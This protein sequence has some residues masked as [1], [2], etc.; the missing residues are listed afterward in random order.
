LLSLDHVHSLVDFN[1]Q[2]PANAAVF[3]RSLHGGCDG[4]KIRQSAGSQCADS[5]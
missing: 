5:T 1:L 2:I 4:I 3:L